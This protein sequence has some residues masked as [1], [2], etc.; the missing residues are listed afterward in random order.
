MPKP[1]EQ[2]LKCIKYAE[3]FYKKSLISNLFVNTQYVVDEKAFFSQLWSDYGLRDYGPGYMHRGP[4]Q[5]R[6]KIKCIEFWVATLYGK[7]IEIESWLDEIENKLK[8]QARLF[9]QNNPSVHIQM[10]KAENL[11]ID[12]IDEV[13]GSY[14]R[15]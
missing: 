5:K 6:D 9:Y 4:F 11:I 2:E 10:Q 15:D 8:T 1:S 14:V 3:R 13:F 12:K 7:N